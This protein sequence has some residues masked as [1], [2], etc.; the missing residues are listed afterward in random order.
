LAT[1]QIPKTALEVDPHDHPRFSRGTVGKALRAW[2]R[3]GSTARRWR[4]TRYQQ[5]IDLCH[6]KPTDRIV[7]VGAG[8]GASLERFNRSNPIVAVDPQPFKSEWF[9]QPN[10]TVMKADGTALPFSDHEFPVAFSNSVIEHVPQRLQ[11]AFAAEIRRVSDRYYVQTPNRWFPI[12]PHY[13]FPF[14]QFLPERVQRALNKRFQLGFRPKGTFDEITLLS[15]RDMRRLFPDAE[16][17]RER[18]L[19]LTKSLMAVRDG[20]TRP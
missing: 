10:V 15:V 4:E 3:D 17:H 7:N 11:A 8:R 5:F 19:G 20:R 12:E 16:I 14:F 13:Q 18:V 6:V 2:A 9:E 1:E